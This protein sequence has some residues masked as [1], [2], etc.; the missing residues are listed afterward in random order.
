M[1]KVILNIPDTLIDEVIEALCYGIGDIA[2]LPVTPA[3]A[4][5]TLIG[6]IKMKVRQYRQ[7]QIPVASVDDIKIT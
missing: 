5:Q 3:R 6:M 1:A 4:K 2:P 7:K